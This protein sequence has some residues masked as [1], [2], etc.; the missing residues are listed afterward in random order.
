MSALVTDDVEVTSNNNNSDNNDFVIINNNTSGSDMTL[1]SDENC[2]L[3]IPKLPSRSTSERF[4]L[5]LKE[6]DVILD[7][8]DVRKFLNEN[9][10]LPETRIGMKLFAWA[11]SKQKENFHARMKEEM[12]E[13]PRASICAMCHNN[14][15]TSINLPCKHRFLCKDCTE[16]YRLEFDNTCP[17]CKNTSE[18][19]EQKI[20]YTT[21]QCDLCYEEWESDYV[22]RATNV[23]YHWVCVGCM[24]QSFRV[25]L[26]DAKSFTKGGIACPD[27]NC[28]H[29]TIEGT[30]NRLRQLA[31]KV[32]PD[33]QKRTDEGPFND[34][35]IQK[36]NRYM[37]DS[38]IP[39]NR[40]IFCT[41]PRCNGRYDDGEFIA[42]D[43]GIF[44]EEKRNDN[45]DNNNNV[46]KKKSLSKNV[47][48]DEKKNNQ[49]LKHEKEVDSLKF[50][51]L[52]CED[53]NYARC[54]KC[55]EDYHPKY[56]A[57]EVA[58]NELA[59]KKSQDEQ[60]SK[61][62]TDLTTKKCPFCKTIR[63]THWHGHG[64]HAISCRCGRQFKFTSNPT[65][66]THSA[67]RQSNIK[68]YIDN[69]SGWP[70][71]SRCGC[72]I[73]SECRPGRPCASCG[74]NCVVCRG[75]VP[76][77]QFVGDAGKVLDSSADDI[78]KTRKR[79]E[80]QRKKQNV[81]LGNGVFGGNR[82]G[83]GANPFG[84]FRGA[85]QNNNNMVAFGQQNNNIRGGFGAGF[86]G[87]QQQ[88][89]NNQRGFGA[90]PFGAFGGAQQQNN[91]NM[92]FG[93][94]NNNIRGGF[95]AGFGGAQQQ[96]N[97]NQRGFGANPFGAFGGAQQQNNNNMAFGQ[98][99]NNIRGGFGA[100]FGGAQQN[101]NNMVAFGGGNRRRWGRDD[102][103]RG[104]RGRRNNNHNNNI[105]FGNVEPISDDDL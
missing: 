105:A 51:C 10:K 5:E 7:K 74:G 29:V 2:A 63:H 28:D 67:C 56:A 100:G 82:G 64:C 6:N 86:G 37:A 23:C 36:C 95:G 39:A 45:D 83:F 68:N 16:V 57:C 93:Q 55:K 49:G 66:S 101:N 98:Q 4:Q 33:P 90:N 35:E 54:K 92:A 20:S 69:R 21:H 76:P 58:K 85:Q 99:N 61:L 94:Q 12:K 27:P 103:R 41:N 32:L 104:R 52:F 97:N 1:I 70:V 102:R 40:R 96:N 44:V 87:A 77:G 42:Q 47:A 26:N 89:N 65:L 91:N 14:L 88:N 34:L 38:R 46:E 43:V 19:F 11:I 78:N 48:E 84:A 75:Y 59:K 13:I 81:A 79:L 9:P 15:A 73:C 30:F 8:K 25:A 80:E 17:I 31:D 62:L 50:I 22:I 72:P 71:D 18:I 3:Q 53:E 60:K 24:V